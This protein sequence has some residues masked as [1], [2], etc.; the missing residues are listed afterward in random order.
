VCAGDGPVVG[1]G[2]TTFADGVAKGLLEGEEI[3]GR[4]GVACGFVEF[5]LGFVEGDV[6]NFFLRSGEVDGGSHGRVIAPGD[7]GIEIGDE[8]LGETSGEGFAVELGSEAGGEVLVHDEADEERVTR[9]PWGGLIAKKAELEWEMRA[10]MI[11]G[12]VDAGG[13]TLE[14]VKLVGGESDGGVL[15]GRANEEGAL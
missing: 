1:A 7:C 9:R 11:D 10:L 13:V 5:G 4:G 3:C 15:G 14:V 6:G 12:G 2:E 8:V